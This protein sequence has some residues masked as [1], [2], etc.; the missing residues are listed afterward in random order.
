VRPHLPTAQFETYA[1]PVRVAAADVLHLM[2][3][4][5]VGQIRGVSWLAPVM[6]RLADLGLLNDALLKAFQTAA[7]H[8][9]FL[10]DQN[11]AAQLPFD[12]EKN[13]DGELE[14]SLEPG[15]V[16]RLPAGYDIKFSQPTAAQQSIEFRTS[17]VEEISAG[18]GV[19]AFMVSANVSRANYSSLRAA[20][21]TFSAALSTLQFNV[22][23]PQIL[24]PIF[25]RWALVEALR[26]NDGDAA[27][28]EW[29]FVPPP[30]ADSYKEAQAQ[31]LLL[32]MR[33]ASRKEIIEERGES[34]ARVDSDWEADEFAQAATNDNAPQ[35]DKEDGDEK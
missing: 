26:G 15:T 32:E 29:R 22:I 16:R 9:G 23:V 25:A 31:K 14:V 28:P 34:L 30:Q 5:G 7:M 18:L 1:P 21:I 12:G 33:V 17:I 27:L 20:L 10:T 6:L 4:I 13:S 19:P 8:A 35:D 24:N 2:R 11:G 3:P